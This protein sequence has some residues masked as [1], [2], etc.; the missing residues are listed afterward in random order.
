MLPEKKITKLFTIVSIGGVLA[1]VWAFVPTIYLVILLL[2]SIFAPETMK[3]GEGDAILFVPLALLYLGIGVWVLIH[4]I[5]SL[6]KVKAAQQMTVQQIQSSSA[7]Y[8]FMSALLTFILLLIPMFLV[9]T[10]IIFGPFL[11][12][13]IILRSKLRKAALKGA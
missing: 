7:Q 4:S 11:V 13:S 2:R 10:V 5:R 6:V 1:A 8:V 9:Y 3:V 12:M